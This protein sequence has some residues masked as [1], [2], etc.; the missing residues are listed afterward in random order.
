MT[1]KAIVA[2]DLD[3]LFIGVSSDLGAARTLPRDNE[4]RGTADAICVQIG[5]IRSGIHPHRTKDGAR[6][7]QALARLA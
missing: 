3:S 7:V 2:A 1:S 5:R 6:G 4:R